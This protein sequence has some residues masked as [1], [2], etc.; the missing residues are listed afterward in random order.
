MKLK[1]SLGPGIENSS[2]IPLSSIG[3]VRSGLKCVLTFAIESP[4]VLKDCMECQR[5]SLR[6]GGLWT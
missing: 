4:D 3:D 5:S 1:P 2:T 6:S